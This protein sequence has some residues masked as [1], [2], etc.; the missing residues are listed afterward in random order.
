MTAVPRPLVAFDAILPDEGKATSQ[1]GYEESEADGY[2]RRRARTS[3]EHGQ[4]DDDDDDD[5]NHLGAVQ[6]EVAVASGVHSE[7]LTSS[8]TVYG[9]PASSWTRCHVRA[10]R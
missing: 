8:I 9:S 6:V 2:R 4:S 7:R 3:N 1:R 5:E 10:V